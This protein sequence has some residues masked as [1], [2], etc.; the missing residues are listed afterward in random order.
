MKY[1]EPALL[2]VSGVKF[3]VPKASENCFMQTNYKVRK[4][5]VNNGTLKRRNMTNDYDKYN[6]FGVTELI[7]VDS[8]LILRESKSEKQNL[9]MNAKMNQGKEETRT[10]PLKRCSITCQRRRRRPTA[11]AHSFIS[12]ISLILAWKGE[13]LINTIN[14]LQSFF[15]VT[16]ILM[17]PGVY[18]IEWLFISFPPT[19]D[20]LPC[21]VALQNL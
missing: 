11:F 14:T 10:Y 17:S 8:D 16:R 1:N 20:F 4:E 19:H 3:R 12:C 7:N 9:K 2:K 5:I 21:C 6:D 13:Y 15:L 18:I